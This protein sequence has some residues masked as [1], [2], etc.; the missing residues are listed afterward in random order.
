MDFQR[1]CL[2]PDTNIKYDRNDSKQLEQIPIN[3]RIDIPAGYD[4]PCINQKGN[5]HKD[6]IDMTC[7]QPCQLFGIKEYSILDESVLYCPEREIAFSLNSSAKAIWK[8]CDGRHTI[9]EISKKIG[10]RF[11][12]SGTELLSDVKT[13]IMKLYT[14]GLLEMREVNLKKT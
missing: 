10:Q 5:D 6:S 8:L 4:M 14:H 7:S 9:F 13:S 11:G 12:C 2:K 3:K 1:V